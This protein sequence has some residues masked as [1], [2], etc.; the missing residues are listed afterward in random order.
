MAL[1]WIGLRE[2]HF[3]ITAEVSIDTYVQASR[4]QP[5]VPLKIFDYV[6]LAAPQTVNDLPF[7]EWMSKTPFV[8]QNLIEVCNGVRPI[9]S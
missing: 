5:V 3:H 1:G 8:G 6:H 4:T 7:C 9:P 2:H